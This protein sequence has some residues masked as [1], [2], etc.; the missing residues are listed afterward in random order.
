[1]YIN[2]FDSHVHTT[3]SP[4]AQ[5]DDVWAIGR[6]ALEKGLM[7]IC[8]TDHCDANF[9]DELDYGGR[10]ARSIQDVLRARD[11]F[12]G[13]F[14]LGVGVE[15]GQPLQAMDKT[16][17]TLDLGPYDFILGSLHNAGGFEDFCYIDFT[18]SM[19][20]AHATV[21]AYY[22][23]MLETAKWGGFD[24]FAHLTLPVRYIT[25]MCGIPFSLDPYD[26]LIDQVLRTLA[27]SGKGIEINTSGL[28]QQLGQTMPTLKYLRRFRELGGE[29]VT[30]GSDSHSA[31][32]VGEGVDAGMDLLK[33]AGFSYFA[34]YKQRKPVMLRII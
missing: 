4:D 11:D 5:R 2:C 23:E 22:E 17:A 14:I 18:K 3:H 19:D 27:Q 10:M 6:S 12:A 16:E 24:C 28:R 34:F 7:G 31:S 9:Y 1:M 33:E 21:Q 25:G 30:I 29:I 13:K 20:E 32:V 15:L 26:E 8:I